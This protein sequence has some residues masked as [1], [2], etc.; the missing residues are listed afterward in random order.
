[1]KACIREQVQ[2]LVLV[3]SLVAPALLFGQESPERTVREQLNEVESLRNA[4]EYEKG[5]VLVKIAMD[6]A[7][8]LQNAA[9][10]V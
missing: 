4:G 7:V 6:S 5:F 1:M 3:V 10:E 2:W 8:E 9:L